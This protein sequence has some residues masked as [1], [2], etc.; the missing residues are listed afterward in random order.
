MNVFLFHTALFSIFLMCI[1]YL[2]KQEANIFPIML[3]LFFILKKF[4]KKI[5]TFVLLIVT[6]CREKDVWAMSTVPA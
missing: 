3:S 2:R 6:V 5:C 4:G 1:Y